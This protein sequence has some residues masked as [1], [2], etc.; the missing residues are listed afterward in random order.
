MGDFR[1]IRKII[2]NDIRKNAELLKTLLDDALSQFP[3]L[4][5]AINLDYLQVPVEMRVMSVRDFDEPG[6]NC[7]WRRL[8]ED[9]ASQR[10]GRML[11]VRAQ[12][13]EGAAIWVQPY[14]VLPPEDWKLFT[15][16]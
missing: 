1:F 16:I 3:P 14:P 8:I 4:E 5:V 13:H 10:N 6:E 15:T 7:D 2:S 9:S 11:V 12:V